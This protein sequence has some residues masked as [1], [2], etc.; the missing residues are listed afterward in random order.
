MMTADLS[1]LTFILFISGFAL[2]IKGADLLVSGA[3]SLARQYKVSELVIGLTIVSFGT[4]APELV[5]NVFASLRGTSEIA[6]GN[7]LGSNI[8]NILL[9]FGIAAVIYPLSLQKNT[10]WKEI[11]FS[12]LA[13]IVLAF[14]ANDVLID[15]ASVSVL[16]RIDGLV[17]LSFFIIFL[18]YCFSIAKDSNGYDSGEA[19]PLSTTRSVFY[20]V[21]GLGGLV[22]GGKWVVDGAVQ[23]ATSLGISQSLISLT[24][25]AIGTSLPEI[26]TS[27]VAA[28][29]RNADIAIGNAIGSNIFNIFFILGIS[30]VI[31]PLPFQD[32]SNMD[33]GVVIFSSLL[34][35][36]FLFMG[37]KHSIERGE[38]ALFLVVY[39][40]YIAFLIKTR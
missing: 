26:A 8:A 32:A 15:K 11:P 21:L 3:S 9:L 30:A 1:I 37:K 31:A 5:I 22:F 27:V 25:V 2:L 28:F 35:F 38:G 33:I 39:L 16:T 19:K 14:V 34:V 24:V 7:V 29:K 6:I 4:S 18:Y 40:L 23:I 10:I 13:A 17:L 20:I 12:L 36:V